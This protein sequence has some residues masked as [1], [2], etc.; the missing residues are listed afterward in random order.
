MLTPLVS[1]PPWA[2]ALVMALVYIF[3][4]G[5]RWS[6]PCLVDF[7]LL[8]A[9]LWR[10]ALLPVVLFVFAVRHVPAFARQLAMILE[11]PKYDGWTLR[12]AL[13]LLPALDRYVTQM[14]SEEDEEEEPEAAPVYVPVSGIDI[15]PA[16]TAPAAPDIAATNADMPRLSR[17]IT[18]EDEL[19]LLCVIRNADGKYRHSANRIFDLVGGDRNT[20]MARIKA[21]RA[22]APTA[23]YRAPDGSTAPAHRPVSAP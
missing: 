10:P 20:V 18:D 5:G 13:F 21:I 1:I 22:T 8:G 15:A 7:G 17:Y 6:W 11:L 2:I 14:S 16:H 12:I 9:Y 19:T 23:E 3:F 4:V